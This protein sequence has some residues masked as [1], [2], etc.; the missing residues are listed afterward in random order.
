ME[1]KKVVAMTVAAIYI[2]CYSAYAETPK[3][4]PAPKTEKPSV[5]AP[6]VSVVEGE[7]PILPRALAAIQNGA[8]MG[9]RM[10]IPRMSPDAP[11]AVATA[12]PG[13]EAKVAAEP[14]EKTTANAQTAKHKQRGLF[15]WIGNMFGGGKKAGDKK[16]A[17]AKAIENAVVDQKAVA[18]A[19][20]QKNVVDQVT[21][22]VPVVTGGT[23]QKVPTAKIPAS[24]F[25]DNGR[26]EAAA[27]TAARAP[28]SLN[29]YT[30]N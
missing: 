24:S 6:Q 18:T 22:Q 4:N 11:V 10:F 26:A 21:G 3:W 5:K 2:A 27:D 23:Q 16:T 25:L 13:P 1:G 14:K 29:W 19:T 9:P 12:K 20:G 30:A 17:D 28:M 7:G 8:D 15:G